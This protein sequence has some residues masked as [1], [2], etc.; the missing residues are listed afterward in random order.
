[1][2]AYPDSP[3]PPAPESSARR[4]RLRGPVLLVVLGLVLGAVAGVLATRQ[5]A[6]APIRSTTSIGES[7]ERT[8]T[9]LVKAVVP[10]VVQIETGNGL[11]SGVVYDDGGHVVTNAHVVGDATQFTVTP[12]NGGPLH[13]TLVGRYPAEDL[14][15]IAVE[16]GHLPAAVFGDSDMVE[17]GQLVL[18]IGNPLGLSSSVTE[19]IVSATGRMVDEPQTASAP[20]TVLRETIQTSAPINPGN[21]GG[22]L[23]DLYGRVIGIPTLAA[24]DPQHGVAG[25]I[26][27]AIASNTV[28]DVADQL[29][30]S[31]H[32][33]HSHRAY[34]GVRVAATQGGVA[35]TSAL[36]DGPAARAGMRPGDVISV[37][38]GTPILTPQELVTRLASLEPGQMVAVRL[39]DARGDARSIDVRLGELPGG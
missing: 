9:S 21:S 12:S 30:E 19:G 26:G 20:A 14:A 32:I 17:V 38:A 29:I 25:G 1:M 24:L 37:L 11:G 34:L 5:I 7:L 28:R 13:A 6:V 16:G 33:T 36:P 4:R 22:A 23:V 39:Q 3:A 18:A 10:S 27:F 15:V 8:Y 2:N 31:G 35:I